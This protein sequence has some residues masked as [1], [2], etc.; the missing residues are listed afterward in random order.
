[1]NDW[2]GFADRVKAAAPRRGPKCRTCTFLDTLP[3]EGRVEVDR[4]LNDRGVT[5]QI[6]STALFAKV[7]RKAPGAYSINTH[8]KVCLS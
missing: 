1:M 2:N 7:G 5:G 4:L 3:A 8:R 6:I